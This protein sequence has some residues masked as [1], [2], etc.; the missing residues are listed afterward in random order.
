MA[1]LPIQRAWARRE[2][3]RSRFKKARGQRAAKSIKAE[4]SGRIALVTGG[5]RVLTWL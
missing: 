3:A 1:I 2:T 4:F 5:K